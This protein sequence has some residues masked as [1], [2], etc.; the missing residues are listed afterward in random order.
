MDAVVNSYPLA[1]Y[2]RASIRRDLDKAFSAFSDNERREETEN[3]ERSDIATG[4]KRKSE[5]ENDEG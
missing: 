2:T 5:K 3:G 4:M 1:Q